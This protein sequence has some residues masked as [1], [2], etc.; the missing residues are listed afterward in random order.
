MNVAHSLARDIVALGDFH[1]NQLTLEAVNFLGLFLGHFS[2]RVFLA[3]LV[4][5]VDVLVVVVV[6]VRSVLEVLELGVFALA[7]F[8]EDEASLGGAEEGA[9]DEDVDADDPLFTRVVLEGDARVAVSVEAGAHDP[10]FGTRLFLA[11]PIR[12][13]ASNAT[14][15]ADVVPAE[16]GDLSPAFFACPSLGHAPRI[17]AQGR[18][19]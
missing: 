5:A 9:G 7:A 10:R 13:P 6:L 17:M 8:V 16:A 1:L 18:D 11:G 15:A 2:T 19:S 14:E 12:L 3:H 4:R